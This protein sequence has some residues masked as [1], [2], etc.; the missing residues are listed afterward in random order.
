MALT[1]NPARFYS[2]LNVDSTTI[3][4][5]LRVTE[6]LCRRFLGLAPDAVLADSVDEGVFYRGHDS[7]CSLF[8]FR[9]GCGPKFDR[10][11]RC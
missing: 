7:G 8:D 6:A 4:E 11:W 9:R 10:H 5:M 3:T 1:I 2:A